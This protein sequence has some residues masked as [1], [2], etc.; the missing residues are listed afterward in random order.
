MTTREAPPRPAEW[1]ARFL[2]STQARRAHGEA[3]DRLGASLLR[4]DP[5]ADAAVASFAELAPGVGFGLLER[6]LATGIRSVPAAPAALRALFEQLDEVPAWV[7]WRA[8]DR[9]GAVLLRSGLSGGI[10]L[11]F[12]SLI[13]GYAS[14]GGNKPLVLSGRLQDRAARRLGETS[15]FVHAVSR[16]SG[17]R[18]F[19]DGF[20]IPSISTTWWRPCSC[21][22]W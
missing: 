15:R 2:A 9:G 22:R 19:A 4:S 20:A 6:A 10:V 21:S 3:L 11:A 17:L 16:A 12:R 18:R 1:P 8:D 5:L 7:D 13:L 14:P